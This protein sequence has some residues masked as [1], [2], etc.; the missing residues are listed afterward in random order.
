M[1]N[2]V[3]MNRPSYIWD[4]FITTHMNVAIS[5][6]INGL[7]MAGIFESFSRL[8]RRFLAYAHKEVLSI[9]LLHIETGK[10]GPSYTFLTD[11]DYAVAYSI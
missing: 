10:R 9:P 4:E 5:N 1:R 11:N 3:E 8:Q 7:L 6:N 2:R